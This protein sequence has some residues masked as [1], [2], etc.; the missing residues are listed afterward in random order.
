MFEIGRAHVDVSHCPDDAL[1]QFDHALGADEHA[2]GRPLDV[3]RD[4][5]RKVDAEGDAV[6]EGELDLGV[7][8]AGAEDADFGQHPAAGADDGDGLFCGEVAGLVEVLLD[9]QLRAWAEEDFEVFLREVHVPGRD[10]DDQRV[11]N[12]CG[13]G[14]GP[15]QGT[16]VLEEHIA[17]NAFDIRAFELRHRQCGHDPKASLTTEWLRLFGLRLDLLGLGLG[18]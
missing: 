5:D 12:G 2:A 10:V 1:G 14:S 18:W 6:G 4:A 7:A 16:E 13:G 8:A 15:G 3:A 9:F 17:D 11:A